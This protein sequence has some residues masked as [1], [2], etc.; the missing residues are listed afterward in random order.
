[1]LRFTGS[2]YRA[3]LLAFLVLP[4]GIHHASSSLLAAICFSTY[5]IHHGDRAAFMAP[6]F[7]R[8]L[9]PLDLGEQ[10]TIPHHKA[11]T[12]RRSWMRATS[13]GI[14]GLE[15][16]GYITSTSTSRRPCI[17]GRTWRGVA[18]GWERVLTLP[19]EVDERGTTSPTDRKSTRLNS[20]H[21]G[22]SRMPSSA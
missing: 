5:F 18:F 7:H 19:Y 3:F 11:S 15:L 16:C 6:C 13:D 8:R 4:G 10:A 9:A 21:S 1:M 22:E 17:Y 14:M 20:S 12:R 2:C